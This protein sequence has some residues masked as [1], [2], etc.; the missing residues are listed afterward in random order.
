ML[1]AGQLSQ[2]KKLHV[3]PRNDL[4]SLEPGLFEVVTRLEEADLSGKSYF[5][6]GPG[7][8]LSTGQVTRLLTAIKEAEQLRLRRLDIPLNNLSQVDTDILV[9]A[10]SRLEVVTLW[11]SCLTADQL[12]EIYRLVAERRSPTLRKIFLRGNDIDSVPSDI[13][14]EAMKNLD[15]KIIDKTIFE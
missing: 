8:S 5:T 11:S 12:T 4:S 2:L 13:R 7:R 3:N 9:G 15:T 1:R 14:E 6:S 10:V